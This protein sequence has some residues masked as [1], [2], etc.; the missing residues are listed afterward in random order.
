A[1]ACRA[2]VRS[3][4]RSATSPSASRAAAA[5]RQ[6]DR[7]EPEHQLLFSALQLEEG[8]RV[9]RAPEERE[10]FRALLERLSGA[11]DA[12]VRGAVGQ[13]ESE[14]AE[15]EKQNGVLR[16]QL[17]EVRW[18]LKQGQPARD[19]RRVTTSACALA[20]RGQPDEPAAP[21]GLPG[22]VDLSDCDGVTPGTP[23]RRRAPLASLDEREAEGER[24]EEERSG[25]GEELFPP[26]TEY[27]KELGDDTV[28][29]RNSRSM[30]D[31]H[32]S[33]TLSRVE[34]DLSLN[35]GKGRISRRSYSGF[36]SFYIASPRSNARTLWELVGCVLIGWDLLLVPLAVFCYPVDGLT[37]SMEWI[38]LIYWTLNIP[39]TLT[40]GYEERITSCDTAVQ[41]AA[42]VQLLKNLRIL[43]LVRLTRIARLKK[44]W[45]MVIGDRIYSLTVN[46]V[47]NILTMLL[48]LLVLSHFISC[49]WYAV[50]FMEEGDNR[51][52][53]HYNM[54]FPERTY[55]IS[56]VVC[57]LVGFSYVVGSITASLAQLRSVTEEES[58]LFW[59]LRVYLKRNVVEH[60]LAIRIQR[61]L[62]DAWRFQA[63]N[64]SF[65]QI[66]ILSMLS[67]QLQNELLFHLHADHLNVYPLIRTLLDVSS[68]TA[69]RLAKTAISTKQF[70][71]L[72]PLFIHGEKPSH[73]SIV[74][75]GRFEYK[76]VTS[77]GRVLCEMV[78]KGEDWIAE[79]V[80]WSTEWYHLGDCIAA[81]TS[82]L[83]LVSPH[84]FCEEAM[85]NPL[86][87]ALVTR[88][89]RNFL[90]WLNSTNP[91]ELSDITQGDHLDKQAQLKG[92]MV[93]ESGTFAN[94]ATAT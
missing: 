5:A 60:T 69:F 26:R 81:D 29:R 55:T 18:K 23:S 50:G 65:S 56:V 10:G 59:D 90:K 73:M 53:V 85:R 72:D 58:K 37:I 82:R 36:M 93:E 78:D 32:Q 47:V 88:Y 74:I 91:D 48:L 76:R 83:M 42:A 13:L 15:L 51:W 43:R 2:M 62:A 9:P 1:R 28:E 70:A 84:H 6:E 19:G 14:K 86:A 46:I 8:P 80:L 64:K 34:S 94:L 45:Q 30:M 4:L 41:G 52:L 12:E 68:V 71:N 38:T 63:R 61:Y 21:A 25:S 66:K 75:Q 3:E 31:C 87:W 27:T 22:I 92:F 57:A 7:G 49:L 17:L 40:V 11:H 67:E 77:E 24:G 89:C 16:S 33:W 35:R 20:P 39:Q 44:M 79:P 54:N